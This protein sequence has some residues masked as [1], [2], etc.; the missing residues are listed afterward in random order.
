MMFTCF[1]RMDHV[2]KGNH[3]ALLLRRMISI[4][5]ITEQLVMGQSEVSQTCYDMITSVRSISDYFPADD[6][7]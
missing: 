7:L 2:I 6:F 1:C 5:V 4:F 3:D